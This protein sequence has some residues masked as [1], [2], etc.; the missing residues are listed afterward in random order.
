M[1]R[2]LESAEKTYGPQSPAL[3]DLLDNYAIILDRLKDKKQARSERMRARQIRGAVPQQTD[4][5]LAWNIH[6]N[7]DSPVY[8]RSK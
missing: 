6:E 3:A 8:L 2:A 5:R 7:P 1:E 4:D